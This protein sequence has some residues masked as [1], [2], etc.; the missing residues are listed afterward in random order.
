MGIAEPGL[1]LVER[2]GQYDFLVRQIPYSCSDADRLA[3]F[4][5][6]LLRVN[7]NLNGGRKRLA[8]RHALK[9]M[10]SPQQAQNGKPPKAH[11]FMSSDRAYFIR[12]VPIHSNIVPSDKFLHME[13][14]GSDHDKSLTAKL[15]NSILYIYL[16]I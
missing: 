4:V 15:G 9:T 16:Y 6:E 1:E 2:P 8:G 3:E 12:L 7:D 13:K 14:S 5:L 10:E 11:H